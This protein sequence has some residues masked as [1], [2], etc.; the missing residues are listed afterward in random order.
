MQAINVVH[1]IK[2]QCQKYFGC[3]VNLFFNIVITIIVYSQNVQTHYLTI[4]SIRDFTIKYPYNF[5]E[6][7]YPII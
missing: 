3:N 6:I 1:W 2:V 5:N 4:K 7:A